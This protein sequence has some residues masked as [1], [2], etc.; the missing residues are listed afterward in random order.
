MKP[1]I[2][3]AVAATVF[4][5]TSALAQAP[6]KAAPDPTI[7]QNEATTPNAEQSNDERKARMPMRREQ[8]I[9]PDPSASS[10]EGAGTGT[11]GSDL[12]K[13]A[14]PAQP[15]QQQPEQK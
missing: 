4:G 10:S 9:V 13:A 1:M 2:F 6:Q 12:P 3:T 7:T 8:P 11:S 14:L 5:A 15:E